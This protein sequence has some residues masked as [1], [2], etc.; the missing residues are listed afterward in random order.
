MA[1][2]VPALIQPVDPRPAGLLLSDP[3][4]AAQL[5]VYC[6]WFSSYNVIP[7]TLDARYIPVKALSHIRDAR[8][9]HRKKIRPMG[10]CASNFCQNGSSPTSV[11]TFLFGTVAIPLPRL[12]VS[13][14]W[15]SKSRWSLLSG[16]YARGSKI[17]HQSALECATVVDSTSHSKAPREREREREFLLR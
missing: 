14:G 12:P 13:F 16:V 15:D 11:K 8:S 17:S 3:R 4:V 6:H 9:A 10:R 7:L 5:V 2:R 1:T